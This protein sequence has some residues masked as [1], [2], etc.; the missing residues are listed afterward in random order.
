MKIRTNVI[1][2]YAW[3]QLFQEV[4]QSTTLGAK[5]NTSLRGLYNKNTMHKNISS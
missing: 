4:G 2:C 1:S 3:A 5:H